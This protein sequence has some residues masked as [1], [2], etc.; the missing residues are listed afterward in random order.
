MQR[1]VEREEASRACQRRGMTR[2]RRSA[3]IWR[4]S[5]GKKDRPFAGKIQDLGRTWRKGFSP[6]VI[7]AV[8]GEMEEESLSDSESDDPFGRG[9]D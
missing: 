8:M 6:D 7:K 2:S 5:W 1:G 4:E 3:D 9:K